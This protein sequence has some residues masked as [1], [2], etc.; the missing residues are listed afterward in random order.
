ML[1]PLE[2]GSATVQEDLYQPGD[3]VTLKCQKYKEFLP[4]IG[5]VV[6]VSDATIKV[7]WLEGDYEEEFK[8]WKGRRGKIVTEEFPKRAVMGR[9]T[10][11]ASM[12]LTDSDITILKDSYATAE[13]V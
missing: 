2:S 7:E 3:Y 6:A 12:R 8:F 4:Q 11:T 1:E 5:K 13:F 9:V 10:L